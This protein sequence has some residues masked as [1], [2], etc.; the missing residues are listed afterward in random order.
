MA[1]LLSLPPPP[2]PPSPPPPPAT[3]AI[4]PT[5]Q[6]FYAELNAEKTEYSSHSSEAEKPSTTIHRHH[7]D[8]KTVE[9]FFS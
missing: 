6:Q 8:K 7:K 1:L 9:N 4:D 5:M 2:P 3:V